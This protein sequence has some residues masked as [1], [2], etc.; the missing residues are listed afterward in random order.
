M[1][2]PLCGDRIP[3]GDAMAEAVFRHPKGK[4]QR[5]IASAGVQGFAEHRQDMGAD[6][7]D[8]PI[9]VTQLP[10]IQLPGGKIERDRLSGSVKAAWLL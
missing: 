3:R 4:A 10:G 9:R 1:R 7:K 8:H 2:L 5:R 6:I